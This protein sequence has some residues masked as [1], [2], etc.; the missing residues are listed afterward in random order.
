MKVEIVTPPESK[1][2]A[3]IG[4]SIVSSLSTFRE[5]WCSEQEYD[6]SDLYAVH[7]KCF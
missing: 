3:R 6:E 7:R 1:Y 4:G 5:L 2:S